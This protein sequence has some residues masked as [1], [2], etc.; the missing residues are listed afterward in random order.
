MYKRDTQDYYVIIIKILEI[1]SLKS[2][3]L[4]EQ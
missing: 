3:Y 4:K 1:V 2:F